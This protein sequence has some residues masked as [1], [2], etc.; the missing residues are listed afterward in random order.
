MNF[1]AVEKRANGFLESGLFC[2]EN[3][4]LAVAGRV[5]IYSLLV[6]N[7]VTGFCGIEVSL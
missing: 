4:L 3:F 5:G 6:P 2:E 1:K 7:A